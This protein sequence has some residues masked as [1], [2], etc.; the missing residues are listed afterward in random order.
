[1]LLQEI[2]EMNKIITSI[3]TAALL[4]LFSS[5]VSAES[6]IKSYFDSDKI[7]LPSVL[8]AVIY[9]SS[10][11]EGNQEDGEILSYCIIPDEIKKIQS[12]ILNT[13][14]EDFI[15]EHEAFINYAGIQ[16]DI[17][18]DGGSWLSSTG[19]WNL[20]EY[21]EYDNPNDSPFRCHSEYQIEQLESVAVINHCWLGQYDTEN[22]S[23]SFFS[24]YIKTSEDEYGFT[25]NNFDFNNHSIELRFRYFITYYYDNYEGNYDTEN[26]GN[27]I[28]SDWTPEYTLNPSVKI[29]KINFPDYPEI[30]DF[31]FIEFDTENY[32]A[33][34]K[35]NIPDSLYSGM[36]YYFSE[37]ISNPYSEEVQIKVG[38]GEWEDAFC[39]DSC[40]IFSGYKY[41]ECTAEPDEGSIISIRVR[42]TGWNGEYS[43]WSNI[44]NTNV[45]STDEYIAQ[46]PDS[47]DGKLSSEKI[48]EGDFFKKSD[49]NNT[50]DTNIAPNEK[51]AMSE[52]S[53]DIETNKN[54][55]VSNKFIQTESETNNT[56]TSSNAI[57]SSIIITLVL[58]I[59]LS[60]FIL[61]LMIIKKKKFRKSS[62]NQKH[63]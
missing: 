62:E 44:L 63:K 12:D 15:F 52:N 36:I 46:N 41:A 54:D 39:P 35:I 10:D 30:S 34:Y 37:G 6:D 9:S 32:I 25:Y 22:S 42:F 28:F 43:S 56:E 8:P 49:T 26:D 50:P 13:C 17:R 40:S 4:I 47:S 11:E 2:T 57:S 21:G 59:L 19:N 24:P 33:Q 61:V 7:N 58:L 18:F 45:K 1:M 3:S 5:H 60:A 14:L 53:R 31:S 51:N 27:I 55:T 48:I 29:S 20:L 16:T 38:D 23:E